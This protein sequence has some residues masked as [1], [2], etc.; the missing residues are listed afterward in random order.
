M[1]VAW[2]GSYAQFFTILLACCNI[3]YL[4]SVYEGSGLLMVMVEFQFRW[5]IL[6]IIFNRFQPFPRDDCVGNFQAFM[7]AWLYSTCTVCRWVF[8]VGI[9]W[10]FGRRLLSYGA[11]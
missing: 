3:L 9:G 10:Y 4:Y 5:M 8:S 11:A 2:L 7:I 1:S 6:L